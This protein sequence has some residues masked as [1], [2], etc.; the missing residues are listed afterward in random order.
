MSS[1]GG[2][3]PGYKYCMDAA[4]GQTKI[5]FEAWHS[6]GF[7]YDG[8]TARAYLDGMLDVR[9]GRN[10]FSYPEGLYDGGVDGADFT[11]G[12]V[13]RNGEPGNFFRA[14][15]SVSIA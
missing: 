11:V 8:V 3:T 9:E 14:M 5:G 13:S 12:A 6:V 10:P 15:A 7:T 4:I 2:P 1:H